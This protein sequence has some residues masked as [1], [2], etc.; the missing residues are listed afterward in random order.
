LILRRLV[1]GHRL[2]GIWPGEIDAEYLAA[3][4]HEGEVEGSGRGRGVVLDQSP[5]RLWAAA[6]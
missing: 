6:S 2:C 3:I 5:V 1:S 4:I